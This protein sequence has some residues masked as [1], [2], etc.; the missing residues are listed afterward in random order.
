[1]TKRKNPEDKLP[2]GR[3]SKY[4]PEVM[5]PKIIEIGKVGGSKVEMA[6][7][8]GISRETFNQWEKD[9][10]EFSDTTRKAI[11][12]SQAWWEKNGR[13]GTFGGIEGY[14]ANSYS[15]QMKNRFRDDWR[16]KVETEHSGKVEGFALNIDLGEKK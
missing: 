7:E 1:M 6:V 15:F 11:L 3:P 4:D 10:P 13:L 2:V 16:D 9:F 8:I 12:L 14:N 5:L